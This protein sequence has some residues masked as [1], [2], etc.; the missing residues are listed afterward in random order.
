MKSCGIKPSVVLDTSAVPAEFDH[1]FRHQALTAAGSIPN[2][3][4]RTREE[5]GRPNT[6]NWVIILANTRSEEGSTAKLVR[7]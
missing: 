3:R 4:S 5:R 1:I 6:C 7:P 2:L